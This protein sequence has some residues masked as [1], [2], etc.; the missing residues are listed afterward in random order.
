MT[1]Y[2]SIFYA[3]LISSLGAKNKVEAQKNNVEVCSNIM[4]TDEH[5]LSAQ[6]SGM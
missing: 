4:N 5:V 6:K 2:E 1:F 3:D